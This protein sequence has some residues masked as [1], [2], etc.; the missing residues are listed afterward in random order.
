MTDTDG[1][2]RMNYFLVV[3]LLL[4][5]AKD[6]PM[7]SRLAACLTESILMDDPIMGAVVEIV[8]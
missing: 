5:Q 8:N 7:R 1:R 3:I 4:F 2:G 6:H